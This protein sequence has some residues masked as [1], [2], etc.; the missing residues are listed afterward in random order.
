MSDKINWKLLLVPQSFLVEWT[1]PGE[2]G[3][4][5]RSFKTRRAAE[6]CF[7]KPQD[8]SV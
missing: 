5:Q 4:F 2:K 3:R 6:K 7:Y 8:C 1:I